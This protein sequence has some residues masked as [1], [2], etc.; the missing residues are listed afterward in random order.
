MIYDVPE[1]KSRNTEEWD[2][3]YSGLNSWFRMIANKRLYW[4][5]EAIG[6]DPRTEIEEAIQEIWLIVWK[7]IQN[8]KVISGPNDFRQV[9]ETTCTDYL[10]W[11]MPKERTSGDTYIDEEQRMD[12]LAG[13][14]Y[15][16]PEPVST[17]ESDY[18]KKMGLERFKATLSPEDNYLFTARVEKGISYYDL[19]SDMDLSIWALK[20]RFIRLKLRLK[21]ELNY[22]V[23]D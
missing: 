2:R 17:V 6:I 9:A 12:V 22:D 1:L 18:D 11:R 3:L 5:C 10:R 13:M 7:C 20:T 23:V 4:A 15:I 21:K 16:A 19:A 8:D 14:T